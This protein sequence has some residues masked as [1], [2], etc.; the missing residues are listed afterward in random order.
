MSNKEFKP[1]RPPLRLMVI[2]GKA[3][4]TILTRFKGKVMDD[5][6][7]ML[8]EDVESD[9][10]LKLKVEGFRVNGF[11]EPE[12]EIVV[13]VEET[14]EVSEWQVIRLNLI[15]SAIEIVPSLATS[16]IEE[17]KACNRLNKDMTVYNCVY[18]VEEIK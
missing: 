3:D 10:A 1:N 18:Y 16:F 17:L 5:V 14:K 8:N 4:Y 11:P 9:D 12:P 7:M 2:E 15:D 13:Q 6:A